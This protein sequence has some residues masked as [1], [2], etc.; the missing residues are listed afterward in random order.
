M[1]ATEFRWIKADIL[2]NKHLHVTRVHCLF[3]INYC[4]L[5]TLTAKKSP[6]YSAAVCWWT[7]HLKKVF[8]L[9]TAIQVFTSNTLTNCQR[10]SSQAEDIPNLCDYA[11]L[12]TSH[13]F[14][15]KM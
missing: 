11:I 9:L 4:S 5:A 7:I 6:N 15:V 2:E 10:C 13:D 8:F 3:Y 1:V 12:Y 14:Y